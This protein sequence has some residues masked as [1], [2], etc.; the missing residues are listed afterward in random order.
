M[1]GKSILAVTLATGLALPTLAFAQTR[2][3]TSAGQAND[4]ANSTAATTDANTDAAK[5]KKKNTT[6]RET[7]KNRSQKTGT[8]PATTGETSSTQGQAGTTGANTNV[9]TAREPGHR[10]SMNS[11]GGRDSLHNQQAEPETNTNTGG[12]H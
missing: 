10:H 1:K 2:S 11:L 9:P 8:E 4:T 7:R 12:G 5:T 6:S 3:E